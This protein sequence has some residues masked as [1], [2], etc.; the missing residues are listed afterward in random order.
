MRGHRLCFYAELTKIVTKHANLF[1]MA[2]LKMIGC[3]FRESSSSISLLIV[4]N[5]VWKKKMIKK[6]IECTHLPLICQENGDISAV[7]QIRRVTG[8][9]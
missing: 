2:A 1:I 6:I 5:I 7:L 9:I 3:S 4:T 8:I